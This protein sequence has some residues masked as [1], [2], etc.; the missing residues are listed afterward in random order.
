M[1]E[2]EYE[3]PT[4]NDL[5]GAISGENALD[6]K[7]AFSDLMSGKI[8]NA[9]EME[10]M[11][12]AREIYGG[13]KSEEDFAEVD[14]LLP[15]EEE[16]DAILDAEEADEPEQEETSWFQ[17]PEEMQ[18]PEIEHEDPEDPLGIYDTGNAEQE[19]EDILQDTEE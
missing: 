14:A 19:I 3:T 16:V 6:A 9:L 15:S 17:E 2:V 5:I 4:I 1:S 10:K 18:L 8:D 7:N 13:Q 11:R 12:I